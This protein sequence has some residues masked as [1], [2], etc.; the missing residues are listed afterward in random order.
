MF[1]V[2]E[3]SQ[4]AGVGAVRVGASCSD[5]DGVCRAV[6]EDAGWGDAFT[7]STGHGVGLDIHEAPAVAGSVT[8][9]LVANQV[10]TVEPGVYLAEHGGVRIEDTVVVTE[11]GCYS[12]TKSPKE[13]V[14][15]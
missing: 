9:S 11:D 2:V 5:I 3:R 13:L 8:D 1:S 12:L 6:I 4:A 10:V 7:H 15:A 14:I